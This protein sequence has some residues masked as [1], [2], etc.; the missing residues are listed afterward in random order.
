[1]VLPGSVIKA[2]LKPRKQSVLQTELGLV[3][4]TY[5]FPFKNFLQADHI[6]GID[7][8]VEISFRKRG[9]KIKEKFKQKKL[10]Q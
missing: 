4:S 1:M 7:E 3:V 8:N 6:L 2:A 5:E 10:K 9:E